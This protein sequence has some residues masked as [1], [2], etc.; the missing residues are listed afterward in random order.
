MVRKKKR[1]S[2][3]WKVEILDKWT[4]KK[5]GR[6]KIITTSTFKERYG[7]S[8]YRKGKYRKVGGAYAIIWGRHYPKKKR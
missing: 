8:P 7:I 5:I 3:K 4:D 6:T 2:V 1:T